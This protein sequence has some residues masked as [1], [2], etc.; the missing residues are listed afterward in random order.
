[1]V[2]VL[3]GGGSLWPCARMKTSTHKCIISSVH[4]MGCVFSS[5]IESQSTSFGCSSV[6]LFFC[7]FLLDPNLHTTLPPSYTTNLPTSIFFHPFLNIGHV[8]KTQVSDYTQEV[9]FQIFTWRMRLPKRKKQPFMSI[10][11][12]VKF[13][14]VHVVTNIKYWL[15]WWL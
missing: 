8:A 14:V 7:H 9:T 2:A 13:Y 15:I 12:K 11:Y 1:M 3:V 5:N 6:T 4:R 10:G